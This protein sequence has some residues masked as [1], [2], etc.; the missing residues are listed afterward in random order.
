MV[1]PRTSVAIALHPCSIAS[2]DDDGYGQVVALVWMFVW[3]GAAFSL[4]LTIEQKH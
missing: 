3:V 2:R 1:K 4:Y